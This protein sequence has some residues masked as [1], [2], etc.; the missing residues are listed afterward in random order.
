[1]D[2][3]LWLEVIILAENIKGT[4]EFVRVTLNDFRF[5]AGVL[6]LIK[7]LRYGKF[8]EGEDYIIKGQSLD[9]KK[10]ILINRDIGTL[11]ISA[12]VDHFKDD[13]RFVKTMEKKGILDNLYLEPKIEDKEWQE[14]VSDIF[15]EFS[16]ILSKGRATSAYDIL[17]AYEEVAPP[18]KDMVEELKTEKD[19]MAKKEKY[20]KIYELCTQGKVKEVLT[21][22]WLLDSHIKLIYATQRGQEKVFLK[23]DKKENDEKS[24]NEQTPKKMLRPD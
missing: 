7:L 21:F 11:Y 23:T 12:L 16:E 20:D 2:S 17:A 24:E 18:I 10:E 22:R 4:S 3:L 6:G 14:K 19:Y 8:K 13:T 1:M 5:N 9:V 15:K